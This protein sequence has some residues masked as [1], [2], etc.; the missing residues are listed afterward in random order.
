MAAEPACLPV[1]VRPADPRAVVG[2]LPDEIVSSKSR[3]LRVGGGAFVD[4]ESDC[5]SR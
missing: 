1:E 4:R 2:A 5:P 3:F